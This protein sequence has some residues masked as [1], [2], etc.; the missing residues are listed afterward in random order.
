VVV[1]VPGGFSPGSLDAQTGPFLEQG[2]VIV[3]FLLIISAAIPFFKKKRE[4]F[5]EE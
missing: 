1:L 4:I 3:T 5:A 2:L